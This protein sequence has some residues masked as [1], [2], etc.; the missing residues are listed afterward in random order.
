MIFLLMRIPNLNVK[1][2]FSLKLFRDDGNTNEKKD[3]E[4]KGLKDV[5]CNIFIWY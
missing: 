3:I 2:I 1:M 4:C 5:E